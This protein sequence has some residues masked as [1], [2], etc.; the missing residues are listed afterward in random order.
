MAFDLPAN[1]TATWQYRLSDDGFGYGEWSEPL[2]A[3]DRATFTDETARY[4]NFRVAMTSGLTETEDEATEGGSP[5]QLPFLDTIRVSFNKVAADYVFL[6]P[7][8]VD[9]SLDDVVLAVNADRPSKTEVAVGVGAGDGVGWDRYDTASRP[10]EDQNG[11]QVVAYRAYT[12]GDDGAAARERLTSLDGFLF[13]APY[14]AWQPGAAV[15]VYDADGEAVP[16]D[17]YAAYPDAGVVVFKSR[18]SGDHYLSV[19]D[20]TEV[21]VGVKVTSRA[22]GAAVTVR[23]VGVMYTKR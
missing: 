11:K 5:A 17:L 4:V 15:G 18:R 13:T 19:T 7:R 14:G 21:R 1:S 16:P 9:G 23:G 22:A 3:T 10:A 2:D 12:A 6:E 8:D 20:G